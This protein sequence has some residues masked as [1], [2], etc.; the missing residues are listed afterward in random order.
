MECPVT[1]AQVLQAEFRPMDQFD[2]ECF[3]GVEGEGFIATIEDLT[4][5]FDFCPEQE[6]TCI[7]VHSDGEAGEFCWSWTLP[8]KPEQLL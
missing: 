1:I 2:L 5:T 8:C 4:I 7:Q 6:E 3:S